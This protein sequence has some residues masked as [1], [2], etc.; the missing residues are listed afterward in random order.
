MQ[1]F[2]Q[3][4]ENKKKFSFLNT[5]FKSSIRESRLYNDPYRSYYIN[6]NDNANFRFYNY[7]F[8][9]K[10]STSKTNLFKKNKKKNH[11]ILLPHINSDKK[12]SEKNKNE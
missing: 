8:K 11:A 5:S 4:H 12:I 9:K 2:I 6:R 1:K 3:E 10:E 7:D